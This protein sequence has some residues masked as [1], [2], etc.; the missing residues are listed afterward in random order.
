MRLTTAVNGQHHVTV[1][2]HSPLRVG[3]LSGILSEV[4]T[5]LG[6]TREKLAEKIF[7]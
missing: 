1:P 4:A 7:N 6:E 2:K 5:H 3:T